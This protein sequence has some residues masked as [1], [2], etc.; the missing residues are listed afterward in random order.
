MPVFNYAFFYIQ[1]KV[2]IIPLLVLFCCLYGVYTNQNLFKIYS[3]MFQVLFFNIPQFLK[4]LGAIFIYVGYARLVYYP[5]SLQSPAVL[6][7]SSLSHTMSLMLF[8]QW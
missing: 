1:G 6:N 8:H 2:L 3:R 7:S 5:A 4:S